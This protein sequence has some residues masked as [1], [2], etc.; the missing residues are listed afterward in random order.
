VNVEDP[1][2]A[3]TCDLISADLV[4]K[5]GGFERQNKNLST[6]CIDGLILASCSKINMAIAGPDLNRCHSNWFTDFNLKVSL[7]TLASIIQILRKT[8]FKVG[9]C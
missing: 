8:P 3:V 4:H 5:A 2:F 9:S 7:T 6:T 1:A